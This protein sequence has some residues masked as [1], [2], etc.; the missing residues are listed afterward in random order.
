MA[1]EEAL[2]NATIVLI[3]IWLG[4]AKYVINETEFQS[5]GAAN[6]IGLGMVFVLFG[7]LFP[8]WTSI[9]Q[10]AEKSTQ[11]ETGLFILFLTV[12]LTGLGG[13]L[14]IIKEIEPISGFVVIGIPIGTIV[15]G[16]GVIFLPSFIQQFPEPSVDLFL[17][18][19]T[20]L[21]SITTVLALM[22]QLLRSA[23]LLRIEN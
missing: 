20:I 12:G 3:P 9:Q 8:M 18:I 14:F 6:T 21:S 4:V 1:P 11:L 17:R 2:F 23:G 22:I 10:L 19:L 16:L 15:V 5:S 13:V 7:I